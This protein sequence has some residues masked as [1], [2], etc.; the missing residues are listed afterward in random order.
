MQACWEGGRRG[1][2]AEVVEGDF[3]LGPGVCR[4]GGEKMVL[5]VHA[6]V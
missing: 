6:K 2:G 4:L 5:L 1:V 3:F